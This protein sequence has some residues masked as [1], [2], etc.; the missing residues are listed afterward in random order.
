VTVAILH[1]RGDRWVP[2]A[3]SAG[4]AQRAQAAGAHVARFT[5]A[6]GHSMVRRAP[7]WHTFA[8]DVVLA[9]AGLAPVRP[10]IADALA[11]ADDGSLASAL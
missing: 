6:G 10:D 7:V 3:L 4:F 2:A 11:R 9:G 8:R 5:V 1:G